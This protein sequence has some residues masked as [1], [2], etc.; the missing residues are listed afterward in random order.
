[1]LTA[2]ANFYFK[3]KHLV[4]IKV[5]TDR[6]QVKDD[7]Q[8]MPDL[9]LVILIYSCLLLLKKHKESL[10]KQ[11]SQHISFL[12]NYLFWRMIFFLN[13]FSPESKYHIYA[14]TICRRSMSEAHTHLLEVLYNALFNSKGGKK[15]D[16][17]ATTV[18]ILTTECMKPERKL[19]SKT[20]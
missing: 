11:S 2:L 13:L 3:L 9:D 10:R 18:T 14:Y 4:N 20:Q 19:L 6:R 12:K 7:S 1:M 5:T 8:Q 16:V 17:T 15:K